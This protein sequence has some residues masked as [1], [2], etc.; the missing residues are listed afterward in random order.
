MYQEGSIH[1]YRHCGSVALTPFH[2]VMRLPSHI[3]LA[4]LTHSLTE[5]YWN[6]AINAGIVVVLASTP[7]NKINGVTV[8]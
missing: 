4:K 8:A 3:A 2:L 5:I 1:F 6:H 7:E